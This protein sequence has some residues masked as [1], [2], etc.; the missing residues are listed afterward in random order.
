[1]S[2][3]LGDAVVDAAQGESP[4]WRPDGEGWSRA[5]AVDGAAE[6]NGNGDTTVGRLDNSG[7]FSD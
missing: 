4:V 6:R 3:S 5:T 1:M 7:A 2:S